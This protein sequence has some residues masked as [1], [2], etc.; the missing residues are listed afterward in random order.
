MTFVTQNDICNAITP[1]LIKFV[2]T[3][4]E[5][6][7]GS[8][9]SSNKQGV[10]TGWLNKLTRSKQSSS[11]N[12]FSPSKVFSEISLT[13]SIKIP[14]FKRKEVGFHLPS[15]PSCPIIMLS[16]GAGVAPFMGF[17]EQR[18]LECKK[19][20]GGNWLFF[21]CRHK[22]KDFLYR[23]RISKFYETGILEK[24]S[25][26]FS[27]E[28]EMDCPMYVQHA[29]KDSAETFIKWITERGATLYVCGDAK[30]MAKDVRSTVQDCLMSVKGCSELEAQQFIKEMQDS[31]KYL[32]D[33]WT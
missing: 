17:L 28:S 19:E 12:K 30:N 21:G 11:G 1:N 15:D 24:L 7:K 32:Q 31:K 9:R 25:L 20:S 8:G 18:E 2:L 29:L 10:C 4:V 22:M 14:I 5:I 3:I 23:E 13:D 27:R 33:I 26:A 16:A 6:P